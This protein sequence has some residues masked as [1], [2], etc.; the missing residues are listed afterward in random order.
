VR[1]RQ[2]VGHLRP[3]AIDLVLEG[4]VALDAVGGPAGC[5]T[6]GGDVGLSVGRASLLLG[7][8]V[9]PLGR[10]L[11][12]VT[13]Q[14]E[15]RDDPEHPDHEHEQHLCQEGRRSDRTL[16]AEQPAGFG[17]GWLAD[18]CQFR[19]DPLAPPAG[20][21]DEIQ[22]NSGIADQ[23]RRAQPEELVPVPAAEEEHTDQAQ[24]EGRLDQRTLQPRDT[25]GGE[26]G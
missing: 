14:D 20:C 1:D 5:R 2:R 19:Q 4:A 25:V 17:T 16:A 7:V 12:V 21:Q 9:L 6:D 26:S 13:G 8:G 24:Q 15:R 11:V 22:Q 3:G 10:E 23:K 18:P